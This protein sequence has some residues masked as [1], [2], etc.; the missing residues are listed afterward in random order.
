[1][2]TEAE[3][4]KR[5]ERERKKKKKAKRLEVEKALEA[6]RRDSHRVLVFRGA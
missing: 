6:Y 3:T 1:M 5:T 2:E 4:V